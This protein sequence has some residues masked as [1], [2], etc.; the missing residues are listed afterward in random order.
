VDQDELARLASLTD[1]DRTEWLEGMYQIQ[2][3]LVPDGAGASQL[4]VEV[5][6]L[7]RQSTALPLLRPSPWQRLESSGVLEQE[8]NSEL[9][10]CSTSGRADAASET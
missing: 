3:T 6:I 9:A 5:R 8:I 2:V 7:G 1:P 10:E 4:D